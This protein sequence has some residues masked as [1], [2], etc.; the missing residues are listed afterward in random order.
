MARSYLRSLFLSLIGKWWCSACEGE[1]DDLKKRFLE[2]HKDLEYF[3]VYLSVFLA[4]FRGLFKV[5]FEKGADGK[6]WICSHSLYFGS[7]DHFYQARGRDGQIFSGLTGRA[8]HFSLRSFI[9]SAVKTGFWRVL[10]IFALD[11]DFDSK[12][13]CF[14]EI[15]GAGKCMDIQQ[16]ERPQILTARG[17]SSLVS[18]LKPRD[19]KWCQHH[20]TN[21]VVILA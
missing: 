15:D 3:L 14:Y 10:Q 6:A 13:E 11:L 8:S 4:S 5:F 9:F 12:S 16:A 2:N 7:L 17:Q 20:Y 18:S 21:N 1:D 19:Q